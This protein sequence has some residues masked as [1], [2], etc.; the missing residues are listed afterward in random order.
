MEK[1]QKVCLEMLEQRGYTVEDYDESRIIALKSNDEYMV[2]FFADIDKFNVERISQYISILKSMDDYN[3]CIIVHR[4]NITPVAKKVVE[5]N[6]E[7]KIELF[8]S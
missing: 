7:I 1:A 4:N 8:N 5:E 3:H 6:K 2:V